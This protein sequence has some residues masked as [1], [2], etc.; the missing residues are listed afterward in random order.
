[1]AAKNGF[2]GNEAQWLASLVESALS[3]I[4]GGAQGPAGPE[5]PAGPQGETGPTGAT[6]PAGDTG[7]AGPTGPEG[8]EGPQGPQGDPGATGPEGPEGPEGPQGP[9]GEPGSGDA[10]AA[11]PVGSVFLSV[12]ATNP[13][14]LLGF[15]TW[16]AI[17]AG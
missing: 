16:A 13:G 8:P 12:V 6:G 11:W 15:G 1:M 2:G 17:A 10:S 4:E 3:E 7:P 9:Q 14:T 5:G